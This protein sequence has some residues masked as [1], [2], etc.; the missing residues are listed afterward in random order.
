MKTIQNTKIYLLLIL[1]CI[2]A[3]AQTF[4]KA[5]GGATD[6][7]MDTKGN[8]FVVG[9]SKQL[10]KYNFKE[11]RFKLHAI[12]KRKAR[13]LAAQ[14]GW[15]YL[16]TTDGK[17]HKSYANS[18]SRIN[19]LGGSILK[20]IYVGQS[21]NLWSVNGKGEIQRYSSGWRPFPIAGKNNKKV[22]VNNTGGVFVLKTNNTIWSYTNGKARKLPGAATDITYD[23]VQKKLYVVGVSKRIFLWNP[24]RN[25]WDLVKNTRNDFKRI[26]VNNGKIWGTTTRN[27]VYTTDDIKRRKGDSNNYKLK[28]TLTGIECFRN[29]DG[30]T[31][32]DDYYL[33]FYTN[34][35]VNNRNYAFAKKELLKLENDIKKV[36]KDYLYLNHWWNGDKKHVIGRTV[37]SQ[38]EAALMNKHRQLFA[39]P[40]KP[41]GIHNSGIYLIPK[42]S[43]IST[44][45]TQ[46]YVGATLDE[47]TK[48]YT[49]KAP[50]T[51]ITGGKKKINLKKALDYLSR[52]TDKRGFSPAK[53]PYYN[54]GT[55]YAV[56]S[57][58]EAP[59][60]HRSMRGYF[61]G[62]VNKN[63][64]L[65]TAQINY[66]IELVD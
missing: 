50:F 27:E 6:I 29:G 34:L 64:K 41:A 18:T 48:V 65:R 11:N 38:D 19:P 10:F 45:N 40:G 25:N 62:R 59:D 8:V 26:A 52:A 33:D 35:S 44:S 31:N 15:N 39:R 47:I 20:D 63:G 14:S 32:P 21:N 56:M 37:L 53:A 58:D 36:K 13:A 30:G 9:T 3:N 51:R 12:A 2:G 4:T 66:T 17:M 22:C 23:H 54:M 24:R 61:Y 60:G 5:D 49:G 42:N 55:G 7:S 16:L 43:S 28:V 46:F 1:F 57:L